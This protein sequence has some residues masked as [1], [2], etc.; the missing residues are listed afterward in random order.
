MPCPTRQPHR[1][2][3]GRALGEQLGRERARRG[4]L[5]G[6]GGPVEEVGV[7]GPACERGGRAPSAPAGGPR[8]RRGRRRS[9][10]RP[11]AGGLDLGQHVGVD[12][13]GRA[14]RRRSAAS[15]RVGVDQPLVGLR[16]AP[17]GA[18]RPRPRSG[19]SRRRARAASAGSISSRNVRSGASPPVANR[20]IALDLVHP[21]PARAA[22]VGE[23]GV[24]EAV[25]DHDPAL[26]ERR[27]DHLRHEL[28]AR[29][30]EQQRLGLGRRAARRRP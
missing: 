7:R 3:V 18:R 11:A 26:L 23:R 29:G 14:G 4:A 28:R 20:L 25:R 15:A 16:H 27:P 1:V 8:C 22:L 30:G 10:A 6:A 13:L 12:L 2:R 5:A 21:Q 24:E 17:A 9:R 19:R